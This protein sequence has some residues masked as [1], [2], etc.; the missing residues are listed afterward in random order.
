MPSQ[1]TATVKLEVL[2]LT[3]GIITLDSLQVEVREKGKKKISVIPAHLSLQLSQ[4]LAHKND[5][6]TVSLNM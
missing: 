3:D 5:K 1:S 2:P 4:L 6:H